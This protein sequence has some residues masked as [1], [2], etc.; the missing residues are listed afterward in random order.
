MSNT[1]HKVGN[2]GRSVSAFLHA[3]Y[4]VTRLRVI[5]FFTSIKRPLNHRLVILLSKPDLNSRRQPNELLSQIF[6]HQ[7]HLLMIVDR[8]R[9]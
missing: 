3:S 5:K 8:N 1:R 4:G 9:D 6:S 7:S 2:D